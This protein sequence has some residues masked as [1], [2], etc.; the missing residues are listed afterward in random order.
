VYLFSGF[1]V[2]EVIVPM[3]KVMKEA[4]SAV[5]VFLFCYFFFIGCF[6]KVLPKK[7]GGYLRMPAFFVFQVAILEV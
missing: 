4:L 3:K 2:W 6:G 5:C 7:L 1:F